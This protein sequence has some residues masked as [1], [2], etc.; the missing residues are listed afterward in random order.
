MTQR[1]KQEVFI[2]IHAGMYVFHVY[3]DYVIIRQNRETL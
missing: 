1:D 3:R 2:T